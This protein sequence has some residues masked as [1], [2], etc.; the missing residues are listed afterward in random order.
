MG[1]LLHPQSSKIFDQKGKKNAK[2]NFM[3]SLCDLMNDTQVWDAEENY[4]RFMD[5]FHD[6]EQFIIHGVQYTD[7]HNKIQR[8]QSYVYFFAFA[9][10]DVFCHVALIVLQ[11]HHVKLLPH[12]TELLT[13]ALHA[14]SVHDQLQFSVY[15]HCLSTGI[16]QFLNNKIA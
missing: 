9:L 3:E 13:R 1:I 4:D 2:L 8:A 12:M 15:M 16:T 5:D 6:Y 14:C 11:M 7:L 10:F